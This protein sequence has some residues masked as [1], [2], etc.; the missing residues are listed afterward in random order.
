MAFIEALP[1][2]PKLKTMEVLGPEV[3]LARVLHLD[4]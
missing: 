3:L 4:G 2:S 1:R